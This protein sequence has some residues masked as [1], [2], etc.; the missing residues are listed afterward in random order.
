MYSKQIRTIFR[1]IG[2]ALLTLADMTEESAER[3]EMNGAQY[4]A[5]I[6][7]DAPDVGKDTPIVTTGTAFQVFGTMAIPDT[8]IANLIKSG[9]LVQPKPIDFAALVPVEPV[10][11]MTDKAEGFTRDEYHAQGWTDDAL[12]NDGRMTIEYPDNSPNV[13]PA[14]ACGTQPATSAPQPASTPAAPPAAPAA[15]GAQ[16]QSG[17]ATSPA[18]DSS[19][20]PWDG[21]IHS[22]GRTM[23]ADG[24]WTKKKGTGD[25]FYNQ[26]VAELRQ[27]PANVP[28]ETF[29]PLQAAQ[30]VA[31][32]APAPTSA[33][34]PAG[35][36]APQDFSAL[37]RWVS[38][39]GKTMVQLTEIAKQ[40]GMADL[41]QLA[42]PANVAMIAPVYAAL[43]AA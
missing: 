13:P 5:S 35:E 15:T 23:K 4:L 20:L 24:T 7:D 33:P 19:G 22:G 8:T 32:P 2:N 37:C 42:L 26:V 11:T 30:P 18:V 40:F 38:A 29:Q 41:G 21:R 43:K 34:Q 14:A 16:A 36:M 1:V 10:Y 9:E 31:A 12:V 25:V 28:A 3:L 6:G 27:R 39:N 17:G